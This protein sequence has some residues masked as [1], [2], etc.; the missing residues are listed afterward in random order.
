MRRTAI[1]VWF[2]LAAAVIAAA[3]AD[4]CVE[5]VANAGW[6]GPGNFTDHSTLDVV[7]A[8]V[9]GAVL[10]AICLAMRIRRELLRASG[11][12]LRAD[13]ER[14]LPALFA[15][16]LGVLWTM[17]TGEQIVVAGHPLGGTIWLG[18]PLWFS[19]TVHALVGLG[20]ALALA[21]TVCVCAS[22]TARMIR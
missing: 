18:G 7:P 8:L 20:V 10:I 3:I 21:Q 11:E 2:T 19:L 5:T 16:Q 9:S 15:T 1:R 13:V 17:E 6:F 22:T 4:P 12:A 14:L